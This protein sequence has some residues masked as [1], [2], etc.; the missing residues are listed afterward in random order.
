MVI[1][2]LF[3]LRKVGEKSSAVFEGG[4][5]QFISPVYLSKLSV[6]PNIIYL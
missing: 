4:W 6:V 1:N 3:Y 2:Q 5:I